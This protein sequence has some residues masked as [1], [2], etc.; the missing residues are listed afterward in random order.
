VPV[1]L[2]HQCHPWFPGN[3]QSLEKQKGEKKMSE[4]KQQNTGELTDN[5]LNDVH[6]GVAIPPTGPAVQGNPGGNLSQR[7]TIDNIDELPDVGGISKL[8]RP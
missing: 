8:P 1:P 3:D 4:K 2:I 6:G 5:Q 7:D